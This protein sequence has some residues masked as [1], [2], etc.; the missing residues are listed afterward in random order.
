MKI[1]YD[2]QL[3]DTP[4]LCLIQLRVPLFCVQLLRCHDVNDMFCAAVA[5]PQCE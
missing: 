1:T 2:Q 3:M 5:V 4:S